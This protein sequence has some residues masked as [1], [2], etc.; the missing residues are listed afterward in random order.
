MDETGRRIGFQGWTVPEHWRAPL[1]D[2]A[3]WAVLG[4]LTLVELAG[5]PA[6]STTV[7]GPVALLVLAV[8]LQ[9]R[10][11]DAGLTALTAYAAVQALLTGF[12]VTSSTMLMTPYLCV[13]VS[14][15]RAG[16]FSGRPRPVLVL[17]T[18]IVTVTLSV[19]AA[20]GIL[21]GADARAF[22]SDTVNWLNVPLAVIL[23]LVAPWLFGRY[24]LRLSRAAEG[25]WE[26]A[27][28]MERARAAEADRARLLERARIASRM[29]DSLGHDLALIAVRAAAL[30]MAVQEGSR[31]RDGSASPADPDG[32]SREADRIGTAQRKAAAELRTAA[33]EANLRLRE[34]IGFLREAPGGTEGAEGDAPVESVSELVE[35]ASDAG[36]SVRLLREGP[37]P[38]PRSPGGRTAHR[39][40]QE[41]LTNAAKYAPGARVSVRVVRDDRGVRVA[42][43]DSGT[44]TGPA[45]PVRAGGHE[46]S[47]GGLTDLRSLLAG[48]GGSF[49]AGPATAGAGFVVRAVLPDPPE[50][51]GDPEST[52]SEARRLHAPRQFLVI[53]CDHRRRRPPPGAARAR[54]RGLPEPRLR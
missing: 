5:A 30:E 22:L 3:V 17:S 49:E 47:G 46:G 18:V 8:G 43:E 13:A 29:H 7:E 36:L 26:V 52:G 39:V 27:E 12:G 23:A 34:V 4:A 32:E 33:H 54:A 35:R 25:G 15:F 51:T 14:A 53:R 16:S 1:L 10:F 9:R 6:H 48:S 38:D 2:L 31:G 20:S 21:S 44:V 24:R 41:A 37:D 40:V 50:R 19:H 42:V 28:R 45:L 11:P